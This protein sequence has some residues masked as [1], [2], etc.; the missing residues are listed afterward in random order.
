VRLAVFTELGVWQPWGGR[1][2]SRRRDAVGDRSQAGG[3]EQDACPGTPGPL[4]PRGRTL[5]GLGR[6]GCVTISTDSKQSW[7]GASGSRLW[8][9]SGDARTRQTF[10]RQLLPDQME[11]V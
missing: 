10:S 4:F 3:G 11:Q 8:A 9:V 6:A 5:T 1:A 2:P 7:F